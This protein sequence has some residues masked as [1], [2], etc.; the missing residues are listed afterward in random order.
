MFQREVFI[1]EFVAVDGFAAGAVVVGEVATLT[2]EVRNDSVERATA[3]SET[4]LTGAQGTEIFG[5]SRNDVASQLQNNRQ[6]NKA[7]YLG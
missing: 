4:L 7:L 6:K 5:C 2:H 3:V 1:F